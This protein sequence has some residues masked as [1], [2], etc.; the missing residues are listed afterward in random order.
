M[1]LAI[2]AE[3]HLIEPL[4]FSLDESRLKR[5]GLDYWEHLK[6][7]RHVGLKE[8][9]AT[10]SEETDLALIENRSGTTIYEHNFSSDV[11]L[12]F[13]KETTGL[14]DWVQNRYAAQTYRIPMFDARVRSLNLS[15]SV[16]IVAYE[17]V[18]QMSLI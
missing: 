5:A 2:G 3:L 9:I 8:Y 18:R 13:G 11:A 17:W 16:S 15:N 10:L 12:L 4:G 7:M 1:C 6:V 14:P